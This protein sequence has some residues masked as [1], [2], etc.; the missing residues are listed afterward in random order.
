LTHFVEKLSLKTHKRASQ[1]GV[2]EENEEKKNFSIFNI[3]QYHVDD[4]DDDE[5]CTHEQQPTN[6]AKI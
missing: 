1:V 4:D 2:K 6:M 3:Q 5:N